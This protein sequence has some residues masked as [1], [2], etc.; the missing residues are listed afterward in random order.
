[1]VVDFEGEVFV[2]SAMQFPRRFD[3]PLTYGKFAPIFGLCLSHH[4]PESILALED[5]RQ[6]EETLLCRFFVGGRMDGSKAEG[7]HRENGTSS[8]VDHE[9]ECWNEVLT[10][11]YVV[12]P[13]FRSR[14]ADPFK[15]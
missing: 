4:V 7:G 10:F 6:G 14:V 3:D 15:P 11:C 13:G 1:M 8:W 5:R 12:K 9:S 2:G